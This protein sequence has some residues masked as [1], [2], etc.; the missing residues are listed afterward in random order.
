MAVPL[1]GRMNAGNMTPAPAH[2]QSI[3][4]GVGWDKT[5]DVKPPGW[6]DPDAGAPSPFA[7]LREKLG[8]ALP[9]GPTRPTTETPGD[10]RPTVAWAVVRFERK[11]RGGKEVTVVE[12]LELSTR[13][14]GR[15]CSELKGALG[16]GGQVEGRALVVQGDQRERVKRWLLDRGVHK[17]TIG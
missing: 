11:G 15:W 4:R 5:E 14:M 1:H 7:G 13:E 6:K 2:L 12:K 3:F 17:V 9:P 8:E 16:V 10:R